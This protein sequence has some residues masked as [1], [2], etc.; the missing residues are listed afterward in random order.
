MTEALSRGH[1]VTAVVRDPARSAGLPATARL[2]VGDATD[3][4]SVAAL[5]ADQDLVIGATRPAPGR[6]DELVT[7]TTALLAGAARA[8]VRLLVVGGAATL[9]LPGR[10]GVTVVDDP[11]FPAELRP[12]AEAC[13]AQFGVCRAD[14]LADWVYLSPPARLE[15]GERTGAYRLGTDELLVDAQGVSAISM[16]DFAVAVLDEAE[17]PG[18]RRTRFTV[19]Y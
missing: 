11:G 9:T 7:T 2:R 8:G 5:A 10:E 19:A 17:R 14:A 3:R 12:I 18:H 1:D 4:E 13:A 16:E 15:P 6:E